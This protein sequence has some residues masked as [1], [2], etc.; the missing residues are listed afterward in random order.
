MLERFKTSYDRDIDFVQSRRQL[1]GLAAGAVAACALPFLVGEYWLAQLNF[2][3]IYSIVGLGMMLLTGYTGLLSLGNAAFMG[4]GAYAEAALA[5]RGVPIVVSLPLAVL[6]AAGAGV[7]VGLPA[8]RVKG[9]YLGMATL[10]FNFLLE[11][12]LA[13]WTSVTGGNSGKTVPPISWFGNEADS[14]T[15]LYFLCLLLLI[16][17]TLFI[18]NILRSPTGRAFIA[19]RDAEVSAQSMGIDLAYYKTLSFCISAGMAG[20]GGALYAHQLQFLSPDQ[21]SLIRSIDLVLMI[22]VGGMGS[23]PGAFL[24]AAFLIGM[25]QA[26]AMAKDFLPSAVAN[27]SGLQTLVYGLILGAFVLLEPRGIYGRWSK[28]RDWF[29]L[30]PFYRTHGSTRLFQRSERL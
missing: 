18:L 5:A 4:L 12:A 3:Y 1:T 22:V 20:L 14:P 30:R 25:P 10:A 19:I 23:I 13:R 17:S 16:G 11:E 7:V 21:F 8:I 28:C 2:I 26:I 29:A 9:I 27:A 6:L 24:G 15:V